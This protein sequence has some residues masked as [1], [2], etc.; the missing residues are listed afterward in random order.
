MGVYCIL[1]LEILKS[2]LSTEF[3]V[4]SQYC[5]N[6]QLASSCMSARNNLAPTEQMFMKFDIW[7]FSNICW[8]TSGFIEIYKNNK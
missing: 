6:R 4:P 8:E 7:A 1:L 3:Y 5:E 2:F